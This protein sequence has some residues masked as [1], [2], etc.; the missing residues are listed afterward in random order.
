[1]STRDLTPS[2]K[3]VLA[4]GPTFLPTPTSVNWLDLRKGFDK[5]VTQLRYEFKQRTLHQEQGSSAN[6]DLQSLRHQISNKDENNNLPPPPI[7]T[8][9]FSPLYRSKETDTKSMEI[10]IENIEKD[11]FNPGNV[12]KVRHNLS[13][14]VKAGLKDISYRD[15]NVARV[16]DKGSRFVVLDN[17]DYIKRSCR[18][19]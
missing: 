11:L 10:F 14:D 3:S 8:N 6:N 9:K 19:N 18:S 16:Q 2:Q 1:M 12:K 4:K 15:K 7:K 17:E 5:F 13:K